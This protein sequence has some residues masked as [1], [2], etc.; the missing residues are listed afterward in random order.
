MPSAVIFDLDGTLTRTPNPW[1]HIHE[2]LGVW[3]DKAAI[4]VDQ[5]IS[6]EITYDEFCR[7]DS[8]LW[9]G[10]PIQEIEGYLDRIEINRHVPVV[11]DELKQRKVPSIIISS[12]FT[13]IARK[14]Q[15]ACK[16]EP[17]LVYANELLDG[18]Q[19]SIR[20]SPDRNSPIS[21]KAHADAALEAVGARLADTL[22]V[23]D[24]VHD[25]EQLHESRYLLH[26]REEDDL[27]RTLRYLDDA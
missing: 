2:C 17:L 13:Y 22:V 26:I 6:G 15:T 20:V 3:H 16:W 27:L 7:R 12:G 9:Q 19:V 8:Q 25:L 4:H 23:S 11:V 14:I 24:S 10:R 5:W 1:Q 21:K 18:P